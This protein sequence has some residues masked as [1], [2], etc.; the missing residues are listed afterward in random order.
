MT[1][2]PRLAELGRFTPEGKLTPGYGDHYL[3]LIGR[4]DCHAILH[5]LIPKETLTFKLS[6]FGYDDD[7]LNQDILSL[8]KDPNVRVQGNLDKS[9]GSGVHERKILSSNVANDPNFYNSFVVMESA[10]H[11]INHDKAGV[12]VGQGMAF[13]GSMNWSNSGEGTGISLKPDVKPQPGYKS[14]NN[15]LLITTNPTF[16]SRLS[17]RL[18]T[19][20]V[21]GLSQRR[22]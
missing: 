13:E 2:D 20:H 5:Y 10:T 17:A 4:D 21:V 1:D 12:F 15:T 6:M 3:F 16:I 22:K 8:M 14:Q 11:Q 7:E 19:D 9:Q 18:D